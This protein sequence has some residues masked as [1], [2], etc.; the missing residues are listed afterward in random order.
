V[1]A[2]QLEPWAGGGVSSDWF[3]RSEAVVRL[4]PIAVRE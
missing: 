3:Y 1:V 2:L 4:K